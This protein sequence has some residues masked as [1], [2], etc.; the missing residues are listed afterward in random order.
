[1]RFLGTAAALF[2]LALA[3]NGGAAQEAV[4]LKEGDPAPGFTLAGTDGKT[5]SL[6]EFKGKSAVVVAWYPRALTGG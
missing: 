5:Y 6:K 4:V 3:A 1:M 2:A